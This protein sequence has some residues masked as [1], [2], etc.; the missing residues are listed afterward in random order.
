MEIAGYLPL[1]QVLGPDGFTNESSHPSKDTV[2]PVV[3]EFFQDLRNGKV[4]WSFYNSSM[5]TMET[6]QRK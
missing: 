2:M 6:W 5:T 3:F 1:K 4:L